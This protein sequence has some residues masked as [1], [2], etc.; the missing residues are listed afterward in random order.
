MLPVRYR[1]KASR[2]F[3]AVFSKGKS[4]AD[5]LIVLYTLPRT[6][7]AVRFG[8]SVSRTLGGAVQRNRVKRLLREAAKGLLPEVAT[9]QDIVVVARRRAKDV[10]LAEL[11]AS[12]DRLLTRA[13]ARAD[14]EER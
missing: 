1:L 4:R 12:L 11:T 9:G 6:D 2:E 3:Q 14:P 10:P 8:F 13:G 7:E 5:A